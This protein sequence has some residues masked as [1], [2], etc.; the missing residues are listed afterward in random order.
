MTLTQMMK[1]NSPPKYRHLLSGDGR[2]APQIETQQQIWSP[3]GASRQRR[4]QL[5]LGVVYRGCY[6]KLRELL[7]ES[8]SQNAFICYFSVID[9]HSFNFNGIPLLNLIFFL[10]VS[11]FYFRGNLSFFKIFIFSILGDIQCSVSNCILT[12]G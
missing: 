10:F 8:Q 1:V 6:E 11:V 9:F 3:F 5:G 4:S 2:G 12:H 7:C